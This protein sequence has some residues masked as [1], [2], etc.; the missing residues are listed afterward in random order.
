V[1][2]VVAQRNSGSAR[3]YIFAFLRDSL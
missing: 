2:V 1:V 3:M